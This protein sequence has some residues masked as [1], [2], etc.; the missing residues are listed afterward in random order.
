MHYNEF[1]SDLPYPDIMP[2]KNLHDAKL[3][4]PNYSGKEGELTAIL[5]YAYQ[6]YISYNDPKLSKILQEIA[7]V[8]MEHHELLGEAICKLG[9]YPIMAG[10]DYW[11]GSY[12]NYTTDIVKFLEFN[13][14]S[15]EVAIRNYEKTI[16][17]LE[18]KQIKNLLERIILDEEIHIKEFKKL[19]HKYK[20]MEKPDMDCKM[21]YNG[22][23]NKK[24]PS[25]PYKKKDCNKK[26]MSKDEMDI[27]EKMMKD[28][29]RM[30]RDSEAKANALDKKF[31]NPYKQKNNNYNDNPYMNLDPKMKEMYDMYNKNN[32]GDKYQGNMDSRKMYEKQMDEIHRTHFGKRHNSYDNFLDQD[33]DKSYTYYQDKKL[34]KMVHDIMRRYM[35]EYGQKMPDRMYEEMCHMIHKLMREYYRTGGNINFELKKNDPET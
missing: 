26:Y 10:K 23:D 29:Q 35:D 17:Q 5:L 16:L 15:E 25:N 34:N 2:N 27:S 28:M 22:Y 9:G 6:S 8:E 13:I 1:Q 31:N 4:M 21:P 19:L 3:L 30:L 18:E 33:L 24:Q 32:Y 14:Y 20:N 12:V 7:V 11:N